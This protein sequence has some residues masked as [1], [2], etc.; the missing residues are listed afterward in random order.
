M[1][2]PYL[3]PRMF[4]VDPMHNVWEGLFRDLLGRLLNRPEG[5]E[6]WVDDNVDDES[7]EE[8]EGKDVAAGEGMDSDGDEEVEEGAAGNA[9]DAGGGDGDGDSV[10]AKRLQAWEDLIKRWKFPRCVG[11]MMGKI[12][13]K[14]S[15]LKVSDAFA[16][17]PH[18]HTHTHTNT[19]TP[20][21]HGRLIRLHSQGAELKN[22]LG[23]CFGFMIEGELKDAEVQLV[24]QLHALADLCAKTIIT[25]EDIED[26][27]RL[28]IEY[29]EG[30]EATYGGFACK[31]NHRLALELAD[32]MR[33]YGP[34]TAFWLFPLERWNGLLKQ[35][36]LRFSTI[37]CSIMRATTNMTHLRSM[38]QP[39][40]P[41]MLAMTPEQ[42][43]AITL[44]SQS[45]EGSRWLSQEALADLTEVTLTHVF[46]T[47]PLH[48]SSW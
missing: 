47:S 41:T 45:S 1:R 43:A 21:Y 16:R 3:S 22:L 39:N 11:P 30:Y 35:G 28:A 46:R 14:L 32:C 19:H 9:K 29:C 20:S 48:Y 36:H 2:L 17:I 37:E 15:K 18:S 27:R 44:L 33:D 38:T 13:H 23:I 31:P 5:M 34:A 25:N 4:V 26:V 12:G 8:D 6:L 42:R 40:T 10:D 7:S 24:F